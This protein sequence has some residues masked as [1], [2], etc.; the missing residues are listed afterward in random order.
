MSSPCGAPVVVAG[1]AAVEKFKTMN[2]RFDSIKNT[3]VLGIIATTND[4]IR[5][6]GQA[7]LSGNIHPSMCI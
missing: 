4:S 2:Y 7:F 1:A 5:F 3:L 6:H